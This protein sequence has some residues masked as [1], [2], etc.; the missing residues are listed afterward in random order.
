MPVLIVRTVAIIRIISKRFEGNLGTESQLR[1][2]LQYPCIVSLH[3]S[4]SG[5]DLIETVIEKRRR[6]NGDLVIL[7]QSTSLL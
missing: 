3:L 2:T 5:N 4:E 1:D 6:N 7:R